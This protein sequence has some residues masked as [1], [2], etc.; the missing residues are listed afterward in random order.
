MSTAQVVTSENLAAYIANGGKLP[1]VPKDEPKADE[2]PAEEAKATDAEKPEADEPSQEK[3]KKKGIVED[4][5][6]TRRQKREALAERDR[7]AAELAQLREQM[8]GVKP[9]DQG[10]SGV[11][12]RHAF[13]S[14]EDYFE[15]LAE[16]KAEQK[17]AE[18]EA[19]RLQAEA[20]ALEKES[21][22]L[23][24]RRLAEAQAKTEDYEDVIEACTINF[25]RPLLASIREMDN[26]PAAAYFL[27]HPD[28][29]DEAKKLVELFQRDLRLRRYPAAG[30]R[31]LG[32][33]DARL[34]AKPADAKKAAPATAPEVSKAPAPESPL[35]G[36]ASADSDPSKMTFAEFKAWRAKQEAKARR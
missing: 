13:T 25:P 34:E 19:A 30:M 11:P 36:Q 2:T 1:E 24:Q 33:L 7:I 26:G 31:A 17:M 23:W 28:N 10:P 14:D 22:E 15:A 16:Y 8:K 3:P 6:E 27:S 5:I 12:Q 35:K 4:L 20:E 32:K 29:A 9:A 18:R 21:D